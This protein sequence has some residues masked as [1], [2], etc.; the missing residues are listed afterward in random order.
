VG[1]QDATLSERYYLAGASFAAGLEGPA[2]LLK[3]LTLALGQPRWQLYLGRKSFVP[4]QP[5]LMQAG[6]E[7][8][9]L[10][11]ERALEGAPL[12]YIG[13]RYVSS[14]R[15]SSTPRLRYIYDAAEDAGDE[16][17]ADVPISFSRR[18]F[19]SRRVVVTLKEFTQ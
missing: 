5:V 10:Q 16:T 6:N 11:F 19:T 2:E 14:L 4:S 15:W 9:M 7:L 17:R 1:T 13:E 12:T 3:E 8:S 18:T